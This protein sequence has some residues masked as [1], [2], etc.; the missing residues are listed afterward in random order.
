[1]T[2]F[3]SFVNPEAATVSAQG[4]DVSNFQGNY[5]WQHAKAS[6]PGLAFGI[7]RATQGLGGGGTNSPDPFAKHNHDA[8]AAAG[9]SRGA[10][11]FLD[12]SLDGARQASYF[13][14]EMDGLGLT[15][16]DMLWL[17]N[18]TAHGGQHPADVSKCARAFMAELDRLTPH[19]PRGVY[20]FVSFAADGFN[21][22]LDSYPLWL[23]FPSMRAP[24]PPPPWH[25]WTFWQWGARNG[26][27]VDA[28]NGPAADLHAWIAS[29]APKPPATAGP[30]RHTI[31]YQGKN[32][33][34][35]IAKLRGTTVQ[36][37]AEVTA[38]QL[39]HMDL[40]LLGALPL[41]DGFVFYTSSP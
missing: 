41:P 1:M 26:V 23:A 6:V 39:A 30:F 34:T 37:L 11:H 17:D 5:D 3:R 35:D 21:A 12:P 7:F 2:E 19:N 38:G 18:E 8:I 27:D 31:P 33:L 4:I 24:A 14:T 29:F 15:G 13:V 20:T 40:S 10:Y 36:H 28:F 16:T 9:L 25:R 32:T 22:G